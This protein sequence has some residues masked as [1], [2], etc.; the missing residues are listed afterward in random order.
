MT[1]IGLLT[2]SDGRPFVA[3]EVDEL[4]RRSQQRIQAR[5]EADGY[6]VIA[7]DIICTNEQ[8]VNEGKRLAAL[9]CSGTIFHFSVWVFPHLPALAS[10]FAPGPLLLF[11]NINPQYPGLVG[12]LASAG[13]LSQAGT[14]YARAYGDI[15]D[16]V[17]YGK[18]R[19][20]VS[21]ANAVSSLRGQTFGLFGGRPMGMYTTT[22]DP[23]S[24][25]KTFGVDVEHIDQWE[26]VRLAAEVPQTKVDS[27]FKWLEENIGHIHYDGKQLTPD[28]LKT[29]IRATEAIKSIIRD[30]R[31]DFSGIKAQP[32]LT[33]NFCTMDVTEAFL[34]DPYDWDGPHEPHVCSTEAD[35]DAALT[36]QIFKHLTHTPVL[37]ADVRHYHADLGIWDLC[38]SGEHATY[39]AAGS[40]DPKDNLPLV[41]FYPESFYF[42]AGGAS[43]HHLA[44]PGQATFA[45]L[46]RND[47]KYQMAILRGEFVQYE[48][49]KNMELM[50]QTD[51]AWPHAFTRFTCTA[52]EFIENYSSNHIHA[53]Y[54]DWV[55]E[56]HAVAE[57]LG[58]ETRIYGE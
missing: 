25:L 36:M 55:T 14:R 19:S 6:E 21:A 58:I 1:R 12:M 26:I 32:E 24:W 46:T 15:D 42:P 50:K 53:V 13:G 54:G 57:L 40:F 37:F 28:K 44:H 2:F 30:Y 49:E 18:I 8:A 27:A 29:Q 5:L 41:H 33:N 47:G 7:G 11:S 23:A 20:F 9:G 31:L 17:V 52:D 39:F 43:V 48:A 51:L 22:A 3:R 4:N 34:N 38:N 10:R 56:L 45:R 35:M 16:P